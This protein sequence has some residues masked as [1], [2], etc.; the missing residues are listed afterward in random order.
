MLT[1]STI[2]YI[3]AFLSMLIGVVGTLFQTKKDGRLT[4]VG[5]LVA[6]LIICAGGAAVSSLYLK[7]QA[8]LADAARAENQRAQ[9]TERRLAAEDV[10]RQSL[11]ELQEANSQ[12]ARLEEELRAARASQELALLRTSDIELVITIRYDWNFTNYFERGPLAERFNFLIDY[13]EPDAVEYRISEAAIDLCKAD[14]NDLCALEFF[15]SQPDDAG[16]EEGDYS[17]R[18]GAVS[19]NATYGSRI[20]QRLRDGEDS[21]NFYPPWMALFLG[22]TKAECLSMDEP[23]GT[24]FQFLVAM[25]EEDDG[26][27]SRIFD[28]GS[29]RYPLCAPTELDAGTWTPK[30]L[31]D[32]RYAGRIQPSVLAEIF[33]PRFELFLNGADAGQGWGLM[34]LGFTYRVKLDNLARIESLA[35]QSLSLFTTGLPEHD[36]IRDDA[37]RQ[38]APLNPG[39]SVSVLG[40]GQQLTFSDIYLEYFDNHWEGM[41]YGMRVEQENEPYDPTTMWK[42]DGAAGDCTA[43]L[44]ITFPDDPQV[45]SRALRPV[46]EPR[47]IYAR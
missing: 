1:S 34:D 18:P 12:I 5:W 28:T 40:D 44:F 6:A 14:P 27:V 9:E 32:E 25:S 42:L 4:A 39:L 16:L 7:D 30:G 26:H 17:P 3:S 11:A 19:L 45:I 43:G 10:S 31:R 15:P 8:A 47:S 35:G 13:G 20:W 23:T 37:C 38:D 24:F 41:F 36:A 21:A 2:A 46:R 33:A 22:D 29:A